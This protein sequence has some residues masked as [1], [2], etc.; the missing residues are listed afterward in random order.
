[1]PSTEA[2]V[3]NITIET[4]QHI[5]SR[6]SRVQEVLMPTSESLAAWFRSYSVRLLYSFGCDGVMDGQES[7]PWVAIRAPMSADFYSIGQE[8]WDPV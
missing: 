2:I 7:P 5:A 8:P 1:M 3:L 4:V 6:L